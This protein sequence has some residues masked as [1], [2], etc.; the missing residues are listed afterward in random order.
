MHWNAF[1]YD[2]DS[3]SEF[4]TSVLETYKPSNVICTDHDKAVFLL[5][6][7][8]SLLRIISDGWLSILELTVGWYLKDRNIFKSKTNLVQNECQLQKTLL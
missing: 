1:H 6:L 5:S 7:V 3:C 8:K 4:Y 2:F